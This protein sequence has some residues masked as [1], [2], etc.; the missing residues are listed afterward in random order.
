MCTFI[1]FI[2]E[3]HPSIHRE[4]SAPRHAHFAAEAIRTLGLHK[5]NR[6]CISVTG[7]LGRKGLC[8]LGANKSSQLLTHKFHTAALGKH[9]RKGSNGQ[10][11]NSIYSVQSVSSSKRCFATEK[12]QDYYSVLGVSKSASK[13]DIK[14]AYREMAKKY[15]PD[16]NKDNKDAGKMFAAVSEAHEVLTNDEKRQMYDNYGHQGVDPNFQAG[17]NP[18]GGGFG[19]GGFGGFGGFGFPGGFKVTLIVWNACRVHRKKIRLHL[20][21]FL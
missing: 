7:T 13:D 20:P 5:M 18:F 11:L 19:G 21:L 10:V 6:R 15:H 9:T 17:G 14:K 16:L 8:N 1:R 3:C 4:T 12:K 2:N